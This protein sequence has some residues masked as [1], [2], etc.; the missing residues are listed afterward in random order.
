MAYS[1]DGCNVFYEDQMPK[2]ITP[3]CGCD[4]FVTDDQGRVLL[5]RRQDNGFWALPGGTQDLGET[6]AECAVRECREESGYTVKIDRL[7]GVWSSCRYKYENYPWKENEFSH[8]VFTAH[9]VAGEAKPSSETLEVA[10]FAEGDIP[11]LSDGHQSRILFGFQVLRGEV[12]EPY[13]E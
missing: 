13:F 6:A 2:P 11:P 1:F 10:W 8:L 12:V 3:F 7:I 5:I 9:V 4:V